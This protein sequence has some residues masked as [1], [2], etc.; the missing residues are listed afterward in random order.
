MGGFAISIEKPN[1]NQYFRLIFHYT[2]CVQRLG[3]PNFVNYRFKSLKFDESYVVILNVSD[4]T[5]LSQKS[6][7]RQ[8]VGRELRGNAFSTFYFDVRQNPI[9]GRH[10]FLFRV[11]E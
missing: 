2:G 8:E 9:D 1:I 7:D 11:L 6:L 4:T 5:F 10:L 3:R